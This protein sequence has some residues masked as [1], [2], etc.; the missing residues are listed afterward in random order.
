MLMTD[1]YVIGPSVASVGCSGATSDSSLRLTLAADKRSITAC[2]QGVT[3]VLDRLVRR[4]HEQRKWIQ[5]KRVRC[6][7]TLACDLYSVDRAIVLFVFLSFR[8]QQLYEQI[9]FLLTVC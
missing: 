1:H 6:I 2:R 4:H 3:F 8:N 7:G 5:R 9:E